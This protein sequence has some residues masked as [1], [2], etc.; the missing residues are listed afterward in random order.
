MEKEKRQEANQRK[1][2]KSAATG[3][4]TQEREDLGSFSQPASMTELCG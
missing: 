3:K 2:G 1:S 4:L